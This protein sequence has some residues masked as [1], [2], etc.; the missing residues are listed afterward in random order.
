[1]LSSVGPECDD[2]ETDV[3]DDGVYSGD[4]LYLPNCGGVGTEFLAVVATD[5]EQTHL[6]I[7]TIQMVSEEDKTT[8]RDAILSTFLALF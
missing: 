1:M 4:Y 7:V 6:M 2:G 5:A 8:T 3:Y